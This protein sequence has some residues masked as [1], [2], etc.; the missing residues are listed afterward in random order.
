MS[1]MVGMDRDEAVSSWVSS[2]IN[3]EYTGLAS[4]LT[5]YIYIAKSVPYRVQN[6]KYTWALSAVCK[7]NLIFFLQNTSAST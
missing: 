1:T 3:R 6:R 5:V 7:R 4:A 2:R